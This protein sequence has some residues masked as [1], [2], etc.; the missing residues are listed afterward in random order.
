MDEIGFRNWLTQ[1]GFSKKLLSDNISRLRRL[2]KE[3]NLCDIDEEY[4]RD[5]CDNI[6]L[7]LKKRGMN[8]EM[9]EY[10]PNKLPIGKTYIATYSHALKNYL[11]YKE[12][13]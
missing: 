9:Q 13:L 7:I 5:R 1:N 3:L 2:E 10:M 12:S 8:A 11:K 4:R 6:K